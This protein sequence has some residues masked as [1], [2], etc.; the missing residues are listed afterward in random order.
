MPC[1]WPT[2]AVVLLALSSAEHSDTF[3]PASGLLVSRGG[4]PLL[5]TALPPRT[6]P[7]LHAP[8]YRERR[9]T[10]RQLK[11]ARPPDFSLQ[12]QC[13]IGGLSYVRTKFTRRPSRALTVQKSLY[14]ESP[15]G[16]FMRSIDSA[17]QSLRSH[18]GAT[19]GGLFL[20]YMESPPGPSDVIR[21]EP[22]GRYL[23]QPAPRQ[24]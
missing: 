8:Y 7:I 21:Q 20:R 15:A 14:S 23:R 2:P 12:L 4:R 3:V 18:F 17:F 22:G 6:A 5:L 9:I 19:P 10:L 11:T 16:P 1:T 24:P 13:E